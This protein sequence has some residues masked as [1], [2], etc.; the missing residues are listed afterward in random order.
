MVSY[1]RAAELGHRGAAEVCRLA[2]RTEETAEALHQRGS[3]LLEEARAEE[4]LVYLDKAL[5]LEPG[6]RFA[7]AERA[8]ALGMLGRAEEA[9]LAYEKAIAVDPE[10]WVL[11][12]RRGVLLQTPLGRY[13]EA[14]VCF[15]RVAALGGTE[16]GSLIA[17]CRRAMAV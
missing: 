9:V 12:Y 3:D 13:G 10:F 16:V 11:W 17:A 7:L 2:L 6:R 15:E 14:V 1:E 4:A 8:Q 5:A